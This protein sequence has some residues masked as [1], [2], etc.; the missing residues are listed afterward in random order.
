MSVLRIFSLA[1]GL[2]AGLAVGAIRRAAPPVL[3][4]AAPALSLGIGDTLALVLLDSLAEAIVDADP[5]GTRGDADPFVEA[6]EQPE[7]PSPPVPDPYVVRGIVGG[8]PWTALVDGL[9]GSSL[10]LAVA[11]GDT[12]DTWRV[13]AVARDSIVVRTAGSVVTLFVTRSWR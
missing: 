1:V 5:W 8:P 12:S 2:S 4:V 7:T 3:E 13:L 9:P 11:A 6:I 10:T